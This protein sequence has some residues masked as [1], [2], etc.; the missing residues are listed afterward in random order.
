MNR[1]PHRQQHAHRQ[2]PKHRPT[3]KA[4]VE[5]RPP[6]PD[7]TGGGIDGESIYPTAPPCRQEIP[8]PCDVAACYD[9]AP[10][11]PGD[12]EGR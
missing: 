9:T 2:P 3:L 7:R 5:Q 6:R 10:E 1:H 4:T 11:G 8:E 12:G